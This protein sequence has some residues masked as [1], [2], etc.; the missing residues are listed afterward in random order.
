MSVTPTSNW[1]VLVMTCR[2]TELNQ[3]AGYPQCEVVNLQQFP[4]RSS[5]L[6]T[7]NYFFRD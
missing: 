4:R 6:D 2:E 7:M 5:G 3:P 1:I